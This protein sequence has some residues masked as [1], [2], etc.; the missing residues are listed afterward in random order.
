[1]VYIKQKNIL[2]IDKHIKSP[3]NSQIMGSKLFALL[4][5]VKNKGVKIDAQDNE[6]LN[7]VM[8]LEYKKGFYIGFI[9]ET[10]KGGIFK[11]KTISLKSC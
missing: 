7:G 3:E 9:K 1:M 11:L 8:V 5:L 6:Y 4:R 10:F 2:E